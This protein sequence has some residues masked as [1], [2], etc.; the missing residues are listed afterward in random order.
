MGKGAKRIPVLER[1]LSYICFDEVGHWLWT[2]KLNQDGY[3]RI[4]YYGRMIMA[5]RLSY[6]IFIRPLIEGQEIDHLCR[7]R[8]CINPDHLEAVVHKVNMERSPSFAERKARTTH[9]PYGHPY[10]GENLIFRAKDK[11]RHCKA[12]G[13]VASL[14]CYHERKKKILVNGGGPPQ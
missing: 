1:F 10:S 2:G 6:E 3:A 4:K 11:S 5:H 9:C 14:R 8:H 12:C 7:V 13:R